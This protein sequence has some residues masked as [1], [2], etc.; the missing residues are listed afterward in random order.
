MPVIYYRFYETTSDSPKEIRAL[1]HQIGRSLLQSGLNNLFH[2]SVP[3][4][5]LEALLATNE[6]G[7]PYLKTDPSIHFNLSH[8]KN[9]VACAFDTKPV[10]V[11]CEFPGKFRE[12][13][14]KK[15]FSPQEKCFFDTIAH[16]DDK[17]KNWFLRFWTLKEAYVKMTGTGITVPLTNISFSFSRTLDTYDIECFDSGVTCFQHIFDSGHILSLCYSSNDSSVS[18]SEV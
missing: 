18:I 7:K 15:T 16:S 2:L 6:H 8:C 12:S 13:V 9:M 17:K 11:D 1:E 5:E 14:I 3:E 4:E 10:G